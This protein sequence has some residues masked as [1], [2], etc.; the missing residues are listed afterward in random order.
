M[1]FDEYSLPQTTLRDGYGNSVDKAI[2]LASMLK[3][4]GI[5]F[6]FIP[7]SDVPCY[8]EKLRSLRAYPENIFDKLILYLPETGS[9][10]NDSGLYGTPGVIRSFNNIILH[11]EKLTTPSRQGESADG[12]YVN[13]NIVLEADLSAKVTLDYDYSGKSLEREKERFANFTPALKKQYFEK[14]AASVSPEAEVISA[15]FAENRLKITLNIPR[16][17]RRN[18]KFVSFPM[19]EY[20]HIIANAAI[21]VKKRK[22]PLFQDNRRDIHLNYMVTV[23]QGFI[24]C[25]NRGTELINFSGMTWINDFM[26]IK[27]GRYA[28]EFRLD[29]REPALIYPDAFDNLLNIVKEINHNNTKYIL[30]TT[31]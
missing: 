26:K 16:F 15:A 13:C 23:P 8:L 7:A 10:L 1:Y 11:G 31:E 4:Q 5:K 6:E 28:F 17:G 21:P 24:L 20:R 18:G 2:L 3:S 25:R 22:A 12:I 29:F 14:I 19:P 9:Y 27:D 30:F